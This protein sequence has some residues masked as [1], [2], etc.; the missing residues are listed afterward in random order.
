M[1]YIEADKVATQIHSQC[2]KTKA[3]NTHIAL[4]VY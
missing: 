1:R 3:F 2:I 4:H